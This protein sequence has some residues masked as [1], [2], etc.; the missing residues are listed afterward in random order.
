MET[1]NDRAKVP[2]GLRTLIQ[3][4]ET[5][6][7]KLKEEVREL[8]E[9]LKKNETLDQSILMMDKISENQKKLS[10]KIDAFYKEIKELAADQLVY[11][12]TVGSSRQTSHRT[13]SRTIP[14]VVSEAV[15]NITS[16]LNQTEQ[17][18]RELKESQESLREYV[19][20][21]RLA[22]DRQIASLESKYKEA[23][24]KQETLIS[25]RNIS[26]NMD[27]G[28]YSAEMKKEEERVKNIAHKLMESISTKEKN[29]LRLVNAI[30]E[31]K[32]EGKGAQRMM[33]SKKRLAKDQDVKTLVNRLGQVGTTGG[34]NGE[35]LRGDLKEESDMGEPQRDDDKGEMA[36]D[37]KAGDEIDLE[38]TDNSAV[39]SG[40]RRDEIKLQSGVQFEKNMTLDEDRKV[41]SHTMGNPKRKIILGRSN[42]LMRK[43]NPSNDNSLLRETFRSQNNSMM[44]GSSF[45]STRKQRQRSNVKIKSKSKSI[46]ALE[47]NIGEVERI[48]G[49]KT[50][51]LTPTSEVK[52]NYIPTRRPPVSEVRIDESENVR[53]N[54][55]FSSKNIIKKGPDLN[56]MVSKMIRFSNIEGFKENP[57]TLS[58]KTTPVSSFHTKGISFNNN[59]KSSDNNDLEGYNETQNRPQNNVIRTP[60]NNPSVSTQKIQIGDDRRNLSVRSSSKIS[61]SDAE[62]NDQKSRVVFQ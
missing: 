15:S 8:R 44:E 46:S 22:F 6:N 14:N 5:E 54:L 45:V 60:T 39:Q 55:N 35:G 18:M 38:F 24:S 3:T 48:N 19:T 31:M 41:V 9:K 16:Q 40:E 47:E 37:G 13:E 50:A 51:N 21:T 52:G 42:L 30:E 53:T 12:N 4:L 17:L 59:Y 62:R 27:W 58:N 25:A 23:V 11:R 20:T 29:I 57:N 28:A 36:M 7:R 43:K 10:E 32:K 33:V 49:I 34:N 2:V 1:M 61:N 56:M 26:N